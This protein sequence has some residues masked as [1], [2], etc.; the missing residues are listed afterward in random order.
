MPRKASTSKRPQPN[1]T[2][3]ANTVHPRLEG[4]LVKLFNGMLMSHNALAMREHIASQEQPMTLRPVLIQSLDHLAA[5]MAHAPSASSSGTPATTATAAPGTTRKKA[6]PHP[7]SR[8][9]QSIY[10]SDTERDID[11]EL[12]L[13]RGAQVAD[14]TTREANEGTNRRSF[15]SSRPESELFA[16]DIEAAEMYT[17]T[18]EFL[19]LMTAFVSVVCWLMQA[20]LKRNTSSTDSTLGMDIEDV[21]MENRQ[22]VDKDCF[23]RLH[24]FLLFFDDH[25]NV[26]KPIQDALYLEEQ[27]NSHSTAHLRGTDDPTTQVGLFAWH[28]SLFSGDEDGP[29]QQE[30]SLIDRQALDSIHFD[31]ILNDLYSTH[32]LAMTAKEHQKD[33]GQF[34]TP[35]NVVD[36]MWRRAIVGRENLLGRFVANLGGSQDQGRANQSSTTPSVS[37][38]PLVPTALDPCLGVSTFLSCY[39]RLL[40]QKARQ[41]HT[42]TIWNSPI[43]SRLLL[44]QICENIWGIELDGFAFWMA[45]C[46]ILAS[47][48]P[49]VERVQE[50]HHLQQQNLHYQ[51]GG[52]EITK[53]ARL[54]LFR[55]D[56]LQLTV[57]DGV[58]PDKVWERACILRLRDPQLLR[59]DF[60]VTNPPY[61]IRK[62]GTFSAPDPEVY[63]WSILETGGSPTVN[64]SN[65]S[66]SETSSRPKPRR[67]S[68][69][70]NPPISE[71]IVSA[72]EEEDELEE[73]ESEATTPGSMSTGSPRSSRIKASHPSSWSASSASVS[74]RLGAKGMMQA[75][76]YFIWFAAQ[77]IKPYAGVSCMITASQWLTLE[78]ATKL[79]A[80]LFENCLM[81]E[82]FQFEPFK[83]FAKV[84]TDSLIFKIRSMEPGRTR[85]DSSVAPLD[86]SPLH[87]RLIEIGAHRTV[88]LRHTDHHR[89]L[90]GI[91]HDYMN[92]FAISPQEQG[93]SVNIM[94]SNKTREELSAIIAA[95]PQ[96]SSSSSTTVTAP[97][98]SFAPMIPSS[99]LSTFLLSLTQDLP[100]ICSAGTKRVNRLSAVEPLLWHRGPNTNPV[101]G[102]V[103]RMEYAEVMFGEA[104]KARWFRPAFYWNGKNSPEV[105]MMT[106]AL[107]K[108]GQFWQGR[109]RLRLSKKEGS[110]AESYLVPT[111]G[112]HRLY[113]LCMVDK[114]SVKVLR[115]QMEQGVQGAAALWQYLKDVRNHFQP[116]LASKKRKV[117]SSGKQQTTDDEGVAYCS[118]NQCGSDVPEKV[119]HPINYGYFSKTQPRQRFFL[120]TSSL[121]VTNQCIYLTLNKLSHHYDAAQSPPLIYFLTLL[122]SSTLQFFVLHHCQYDQQGRM[123]LFRESMAKIPF[124]DRDVK[125][126]PQRIHYA[127]QLGQRM[128][129]LKGILY[130]AV[131]EWN[132]TGSNSRTD[133][134][135]PRLSEPFVGS[136]GGNQG[137]LDWIRRG[138]DPP[139]GVLPKTRD[140][141]W[142]MLES[143]SS[144]PTTRSPPPSS[145]AQLSTSAPPALPA[146]GAHFHRAGSLMSSQADID[147]DTN[148]GTDTDTD[149]DDN[150]DA[151]RG[152]RFGQEEDFKQTLQREYQHSLQEPR[153][154]FPSRQYNQ[155]RSQSW[156]SSSNDPTQSSST[157]HPPSHPLR[158]S[159]H[160]HTPQPR[161]PLQNQD[162]ECDAIMRAL[163]RAVSMV[164]MLQW[165]VDQYGYMLYGIQPR[166]QKLLELELKVA[167]GSRLDAIIAHLPSPVSEPLSLPQQHQQPVGPL[168]HD[169]PM[170]SGEE[171]TFGHV[172]DPSTVP[173]SGMLSTSAP[174]ALYSTPLSPI[175]PLRPILPRQGS[176]GIPHMRPPLA[177][178]TPAVSVRSPSNLEQDLGITVSELQRWDKSEEDDTASVAV[179]L[180]AQSI[181]ENAQAAVSSLEDLLRRYPSFVK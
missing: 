85:Q 107:H 179:P 178:Q 90:D 98:Y 54:H 64:M 177:A 87:H 32:V 116:G 59:F 12:D 20:R 65:V 161:R 120:D 125:S 132:L 169:Q 129:D 47:L 159:T 160:R 119:V 137:L 150:F 56:T 181:M 123:R 118:T 9:S 166:F 80:W 46:G 127:A 93:S 162:A 115:E 41:D 109:D 55:N 26:L 35:S 141:I 2:I 101:Y 34:Y 144:A 14:T 76:G 84:Q 66:P 149:I 21:D 75:Y 157:P 33:H 11:S 134:G 151:G 168:D 7:P 106:K 25:D 102:L 126:S 180:Y 167:Y 112:S 88:F 17:S 165:A 148:T 108:E 91:L 121:A 153:P 131:M 48:I 44:A 173:E 175:A 24:G 152:S 57:P 82:F 40:I 176:A 36:F 6:P 156:M 52:E 138:G 147:T 69:S 86:Q 37:E 13:D 23:E 130:K 70:P 49:L 114:E 8:L 73:S 19:S 158:S 3:A 61:M 79:R 29:L 104:M 135:A 22:P 172:E 38:A 164:E 31:V 113:G 117:S 62:T 77:R 140:Q 110:P 18:I 81:D 45:R 100:G 83:V 105:G 71:D 145:I 60:I 163:E 171:M 146:L 39:V 58:H 133:L 67:G 78:F 92:F 143:H 154:G 103:V 16:M 136:I 74:M 28:F 68:T 122:N 51:T 53:L 174:P 10:F 63:D 5:L 124:Q 111:P 4:V 30:V 139:T 99:L 89:P 42:N 43:A 50:L 27:Q 96:P 94:V 97:T 142:R 1:D 155:Q 95:P 15:G 170:R 72:A 128:I